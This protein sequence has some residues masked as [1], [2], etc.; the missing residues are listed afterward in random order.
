MYLCV[1][2]CVFYRLETVNSTKPIDPIPPG[3]SK[4]KRMV[5]F[6]SQKLELHLS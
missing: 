4:P 5:N 2:V 3:N 1:C 6:V